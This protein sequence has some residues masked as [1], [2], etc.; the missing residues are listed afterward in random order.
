[1]RLQLCQV[2]LQRPVA[3]R[4]LDRPPHTTPLPAP[5]GAHPQVGLKGVVHITG[6]GMTENIPRVIPKG[7][8]VQISTS[9][10]EVRRPRGWWGGQGA[11]RG[12]NCQ[13]RARVCG[14][15]CEQAHSRAGHLACAQQP[16]CPR[17][18][19]PGPLPA[20][21]AL[22]LPPLFKWLQS[23]GGISNAEMRRTFNCG[24]GNILVVNPEDVAAAQAVDPELWAV[25]RVVEGDGVTYVH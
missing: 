8:G 5:P 11:P 3:G 13:S 12:G 10:W 19:D 25:G 23:A 24:V 6:G 7:L 18:S 15:K 9:S 22:Q 2:L 17:P 20:S 14:I 1:M 16:I 4:C 21:R